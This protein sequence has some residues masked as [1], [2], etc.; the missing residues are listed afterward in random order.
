MTFPTPVGCDATREHGRRS[1]P[2]C[3]G[4]MTFTRQEEC[5]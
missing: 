4:R 3:R 5:P 2:A 1:G